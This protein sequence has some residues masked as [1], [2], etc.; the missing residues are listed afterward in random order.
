MASGAVEVAPEIMSRSQIDEGAI[1]TYGAELDW[2]LTL[3]E[4]ARS[5]I[6]EPLSTLVLQI[7]DR[8]AATRVSKMAVTAHRSSAKWCYCCFTIE[9]PGPQHREISC[10]IDYA[11]RVENVVSVELRL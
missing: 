5:V 3:S 9:D 7:S 4:R 10:L 6:N 11:H 8:R 2:N 1:T